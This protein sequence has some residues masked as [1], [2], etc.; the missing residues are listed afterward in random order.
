[1]IKRKDQIPV[2][3][4]DREIFILQ[5]LSDVGRGRASL[6]LDVPKLGVKLGVKS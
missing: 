1:M 6:L 5:G 3:A 2:I 4:D